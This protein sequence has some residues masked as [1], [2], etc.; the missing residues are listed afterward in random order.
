VEVAMD[1]ELVTVRELKALN[2]A[3]HSTIASLH[4]AH[5][6]ILR[7]MVEALERSLGEDYRHEL[8][9]RLKETWEASQCPKHDSA[10][11]MAKSACETIQEFI[12]SLEER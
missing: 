6:V 1:E 8:A 10:S 2:E 9:N 12:N 3:L 7:E 11:L 4:I 5:S